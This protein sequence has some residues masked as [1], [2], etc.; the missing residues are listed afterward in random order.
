MWNSIK[1]VQLSLICTKIVILLIIIC[2]I[3]LPKILARYIDYAL[4]PIEISNLYPFMAILYLC[5]IPA[6]TALACL[7]LLLS[8]IRK[9]K[10]FVKG[11]VKLLRVISWC[12]F[13]T[14]LI[15]VFAVKYYLL[16]GLVGVTFGF[17]GLVLRVVKNVIEEAVLLKAESE[18]TI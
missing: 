4:I 13:I 14:A 7:H 6:M 8:N 9:E 10:V 11:N 1:S 18:L 3:F 5:C 2:A 17:L 15:L 12:C 16:I